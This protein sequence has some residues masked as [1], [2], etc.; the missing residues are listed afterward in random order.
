M[1]AVVSRLGCSGDYF[2]TVSIVA[3]QPHPDLN[4]A[5]ALTEMIRAGMTSVEIAN[6][7]DRGVRAVRAATRRHRLANPNDPR[8]PE[9]SSV[10]VD[11]AWL[12]SAHYDRGLSIVEIAREIH[13]APALVLQ[14]FREFSIP[15]RRPRTYAQLADPEWLR[16]QFAAGST[17]G[18]IAASVGCSKSAIRFAV[19]QHAISPLVRMPACQPEPGELR[20]AWA[21]AG[22][23]KALGRRYHVRSTTAARWLDDAHIAR[24]RRRTQAPLS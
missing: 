8:S 23:L 9:R 22:S 3:R 1:R 17:A 24:G 12:R 6:R 13:R 10:L 4:N 18:E 20:A 5:Q 16:A 14:S 7:I 11:A 15:T 21:D 19:S 2:N